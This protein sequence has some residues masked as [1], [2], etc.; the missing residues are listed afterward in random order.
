MDALKFFQIRKNSVSVFLLN[1]TCNYGL[2]PFILSS[3]LLSSSL[4]LGIDALSLYRCLEILNLSLAL[5]KIIS[6]LLNTALGRCP[7]EGKKMGLCDL[8]ICD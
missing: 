1:L 2:G 8:C 5:R 6:V 4:L 7:G 3:D